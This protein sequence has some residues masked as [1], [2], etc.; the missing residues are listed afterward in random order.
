MSNYRFKTLAE[1]TVYKI[2]AAAIVDIEQEYENGRNDKASLTNALLVAA[3]GAVKIK[4]ETFSGSATLEAHTADDVLQI[5]GGTSA[6]MTVADTKFLSLEAGRNDPAS[7]ANGL[8]K[9]S[10]GSVKIKGTTFNGTRT[11][12]PANFVR[13]DQ[14]PYGDPDNPL[15][16]AY[17]PDFPTPSHV[18][19]NDTT[20]GVPGSIPLSNVMPASG[21]TS[22]KLYSAQDEID[23]NEIPNLSLI[24]TTASGG[25][26][27]W[28]IRNVSRVGTWNLTA[29]ETARN[30]A[31]KALYKLAEHFNLLGV[32]TVGEYAGGG[33]TAPPI[34]AVRSVETISDTILRIDVPLNLRTDFYLVYS[35]VDNYTTSIGRID[36]PYIYLDDTVGVAGTTR[37]YKILAGNTVG[38]SAKSDAVS[39]TT[40]TSRTASLAKTRIR[41]AIKYGL[42]TI[43]AGTPIGDYT[44]QSTIREVCDPPK[45]PQ[46]FR[47]CIAVNL[48][49]GK[50]QSAESS[51]M[52]QG[53]NQG[54]LHESFIVTLDCYMNE[55]DDPA[56]AQDK[57]LADL[58]AYFGKYSY[59]PDAYGNATAFNCIFQDA[60]PFGLKIQNPNCGITVTFRVWYRIYRS[61]PLRSA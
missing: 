7:L 48:L 49:F 9:S 55:N 12:A 61:N 10:A 17:A 40:A 27:A 3:A 60:I 35:S 23:R 39:G 22:D 58:Q 52:K 24:P 31:L 53:D 56:L 14:A 15:I 47:E 1:C 34:P 51:V 41:E 54:L 37:S 21:G 13:D 38:N 32:D 6:K 46:G 28:L 44:F 59:I 5:S 25:P 57:L 30:T 2:K 16:P 29:W 26:V 19:E 50:D 18:T 20:Q 43:I 8:L 42:G 36:P 4:G 33:L 11:D 45:H